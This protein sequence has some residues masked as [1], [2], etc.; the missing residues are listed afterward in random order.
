MNATGLISALILLVIVGALIILLT[1]LTR[2]TNRSAEVRDAT[3]LAQLARIDRLERQVNH[4]MTRLGIAEPPEPAADPIRD[5]VRGGHKIEA[6]K[7]YRERH[8]VGLRAAKEAVEAI[9]EGGAPAGGRAAD[10]RP[11]A[12]P[13]G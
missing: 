11:P 1:L 13:T 4:L 7:L 12:A 6:I 8:G 10:G 2:L 9:M 5:L 3:R